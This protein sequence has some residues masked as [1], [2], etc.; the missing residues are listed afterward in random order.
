MHA[1]FIN[2]DLQLRVDVPLPRPLANEVL[3]RTRC[4]GICN[5]DLE[6]ARGMYGFTGIPG[7]EFCGEVIEGP[8]S[9]RGARVAGEITVY[10]ARCSLC[11]A[12]ATSQ[13][14]ARKTLGIHEYPGAFAEYFCLP[15][16]NLHAVPDLVSDEAAVFTEPLAAALQVTEAVHV[17]PGVEALVLGA[18]KL[19]LLIA[20]VLRLAGADVAAVVRHDR[21]ARLLRSWGIAPLAPE[22]IAAQSVPL[23][24]EVTGSA[25]GLATALRLVRSRGTIVLKSTYH[26]EPRVDMTQVAVREI[27][28]VGSR[29]GPFAPALNLLE[30]G[31]VNVQSMIDGRFPLRDG[32]RAMERAARPGSL[33]ILLDFPQQDTIH[34]TP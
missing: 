4:A 27:T 20:Q 15:V 31:L 28:L 11:R 3:I 21:Q 12:G 34:G 19:G 23:V 8:D 5:T 24:V 32:V 33:K 26:G 9:W 30:Q 10:C 16:A 6:L 22:D 2:G 14:L 13:C 18:G 29:C 1:L 17:Q 7:H 25:S